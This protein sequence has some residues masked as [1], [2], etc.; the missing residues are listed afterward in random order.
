MRLPDDLLARAAD[1][2]GLL[3]RAQ[4]RGGAVTADAL[5]WRLGRSWSL[6][7]P[8]VVSTASRPLTTSQKLV[9]ALLEAG[10]DAVVTGHHGLR[11]ARGDI[12]THRQAGGGAGTGWARGAG[13]RLPARA[14]YPSP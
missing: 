6:V 14:P 9:A 7:L 2:Q 3:T 11:L 4:L 5:R 12:G 8:T 13:R 10:P 1:Q